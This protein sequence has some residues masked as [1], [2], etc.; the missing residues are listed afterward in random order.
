MKILQYYNKKLKIRILNLTNRNIKQDIKNKKSNLFEKP[1][2]FFAKE[3][4]I[5]ST[6][7]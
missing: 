5:S 2:I 1:E 3:P 7:R 6:P 4:K